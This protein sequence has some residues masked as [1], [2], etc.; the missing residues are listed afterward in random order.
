MVHL[1]LDVPAVVSEDSGGDTKRF[2]SIYAHTNPRP[3]IEN[4]VIVKQGDVIATLADTSNSKTNIIPHLHFS[5]GI[6]SKSFSYDGFVW[7]TIR[8]PELITLLNPLAVI[9]W[10][11][12]A[13]YAESYS[14]RKL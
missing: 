8:K 1:L 13:L 4:S 12:Q 7:N 14:C 6:P 3:E 5:L 9:D 10:P 2:I 11:Y